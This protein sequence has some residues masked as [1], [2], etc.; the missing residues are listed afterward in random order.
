M[1]TGVR[2]GWSASSTVIQDCAALVSNNPAGLGCESRS[3]AA[4]AGRLCSATRDE[5]SSAINT[6]LVMVDAFRSEN[7]Y[8]FSRLGEMG[9]WPQRCGFLNV[10]GVLCDGV[11][12]LQNAVLELKDGDVSSR[13]KKD[14]SHRCAA[15]ELGLT[16]PTQRA[17]PRRTPHTRKTRNWKHRHGFY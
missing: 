4:F 1:P 2:S 10:K 5:A 6:S 13:P 12:I 14:G 15:A 9:S 17:G 11:A 16:V 7:V 3:D 8:V